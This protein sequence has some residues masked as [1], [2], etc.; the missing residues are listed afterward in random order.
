MM[1]FILGRINTG[2]TTQVI[3]DIKELVKSGKEVILLVPEQ[4]SFE[5]EKMILDTF[6]N[7]ANVN[8]EVLT[9]TRLCEVVGREVGGLCGKQLTNADKYL[10]MTRAV[11]SVSDELKLWGKYSSSCGFC[12][13]ILNTIDELKV[14]AITPAD[15]LSAVN[16]EKN[17]KIDDK[18][19]DTYLIYESYE[20]LLGTAFLDPSDK[21]KRLYDSLKKA[22]YLNNKAVV[23]D[24]FKSFSGGQYKIIDRIISKCDDCIFSLSIDEND[25]R[26]FG[27][28]KNIREVKRKIEEIAK[29]HNKLPCENICLS[30]T[31]YENEDLSAL[32]KGMFYSDFSLLKS[33]ENI[34]VSRAKNIYD[35]CEYVAKTIREII[36][37]NGAKYSD[38]S[39]FV[40]DTAVYEDALVCAC[41]R[42]KVHCFIDRKFPLSATPVSAFVLSA[43]GF[44]KRSDT[45][46]IFAFL[47]SGISPLS[48]EELS[49][50]ENYAYIWNIKASRWNEE[51]KMNPSG[52]TERVE[53]DTDEKL[54]YINSL[55][56]KAITPL[57]AFKKNC[58]GTPKQIGEAILK[59]FSDI[60]GKETLKYLKNY[61]EENGDIQFSEILCKAFDS[62]I[63]LL[64]VIVRCHPDTAM[65]VSNYYDALK[66]SLSLQMISVTPQTLDEVVFS[67]ADRTSSIKRP[68]VFVMGINEGDF[69][70]NY[71]QNGLFTN[72][73]RAYL[74]EK[75]LEIPDLTIDRAID[76]EYLVY[77]TLSSATK[78][79]YLSYSETLSNGSASTMSAFLESMC[80]TAK[81]TPVN[82]SDESLKQI[83]E[84]IDSAYFEYL[85]RALSEDVYA[86]T[87]REVLKSSEKGKDLPNLDDIVQNKA[88]ISNETA[89]KLYGKNLY[90][91]PSKFD[92]Y[93]RCRFMYFCG[94]ALKAKKLY[95][96]DFNVM[97]RGTV[98]HYV[99]QRTVETYKKGFCDFSDEEIS[100]IVDKFIKE[101]LDSVIGF[102]DADN[103]RL[104]YLVSTIKVTLNYVVKRLAQEFAQSDFEPVACELNFA[105][106]GELPPITAD[107]NYG[108]KLY[109]T[110]VIDRLDTY[111]SYVR[112]VDYKTGSRYFKLP[113]ILF[114]QNMQM[115]LYLYTVLK[116]KTYG[117]D[118]A[119]ILYM[120]AKVLYEKAPKERRM[121][122]LI[123]ANS[124]VA[125]AMDKENKGEYIPKFKE[126]S[127]SDS[128]LT[129]EEFEKVFSFVDRKLKIIGDDIISGKIDANPID[130]LDSSACK[131]CDFASV[132]RMEGKNILS[133]PKLSNEEVFEKI[134]KGEEVNA[135]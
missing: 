38:F 94:D 33:P 20:Q 63:N 54:A 87:L 47:K 113:D 104:E 26:E 7:N 83:P 12:E 67:C 127:P 100:A 23:F 98:V 108:G 118:S 115:L 1:K 70:K 123:A 128:F 17:G 53:E 120:P 50:L 16:S 126:D 39:V 22:E 57:N 84:T 37:T 73:E 135:V 5:S 61:Y 32:E 13:S 15:L 52:L 109:L 133:V 21:L 4:Y 76:E 43:L 111:K 44:I 129:K 79:I 48:T 31:H 96:A 29:K 28:Q 66:V 75:G 40:R 106:D 35:E 88:K 65:S 60:N 131:Y 110:G 25:E 8:I 93:C 62:L 74:K 55:R 91:S 46:S 119:G 105:R 49:T 2:K 58:K 24:G 42:N 3:K 59:L 11:K 56:I 92:K 85:K 14:N 90:L 27:I 103:V 9:F 130:G 72:T 10:L 80:K 34:V 51:W 69:P 89:Q 81:I 82:V 30:E 121:N 114:G 36:R 124:E 107:L 134:E 122:G 99:L 101:Y 117:E 6:G 78:K 116:N 125:S 102:N 95:P 132:C 18:I 68:Y 45:K 112:I 97:Q 19:R 77:E 64:D 71:K 41:E 86:N